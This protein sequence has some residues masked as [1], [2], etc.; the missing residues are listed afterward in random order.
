MSAEIEGYYPMACGRA[1]FVAGG[2]HLNCP[3]LHSPRRD[4]LAEL[5][6][7]S[8]AESRDASSDEGAREHVR[9]EPPGYWRVAGG[10]PALR[11]PADLKPLAALTVHGT[12]LSPAWEAYL[13]EEG[14]S[15]HP[16][17]MVRQ[18]VMAAAPLIVADELRR[19]AECI[20]GDARGHEVLRERTDEIEA[21]A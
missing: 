19:P 13:A 14:H 16:T 2:K 4:A 3:Y 9:P 10:L 18:A 5:L 17:E 21:P 6:A 11:S 20:E 15:D 1:L 12:P 7:D 8:D